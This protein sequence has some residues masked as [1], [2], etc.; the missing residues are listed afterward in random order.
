MSTMKGKSGLVPSACAATRTGQTSRKQAKSAKRRN[1]VD[2]LGKVAHR[3]E[4]RSHA[5]SECRGQVDNIAQKG[6]PETHRWLRSNIA[7][8]VSF[9]NGTTAGGTVPGNGRRCG[10]ANTSAPPIPCQ[11]KMK[12]PT[13]ATV[14]P[15]RNP[16]SNF[17]DSRSTLGYVEA[18]F[19]TAWRRAIPMSPD[20][21]DL[22]QRIPAGRSTKFT[23]KKTSQP[24]Q[25][26]SPIWTPAPRPP[27]ASTR[28][29]SSPRPAQS[30]TAP[31][32]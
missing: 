30:E 17:L 15:S 14:T 25:I 21:T 32:P 4:K 23:D 18:D 6:N 19:P 16:T 3:F 13:H 12:A 26:R 20:F 8:S 24:A 11:P 1:M 28:R 9:L 31:P 5:H 29:P 2:L 27:L 7:T 10:R 22:P